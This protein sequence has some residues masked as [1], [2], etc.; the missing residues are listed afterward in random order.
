MMI[1]I[2]GF[3][4]RGDC[5]RC[6]ELFLGPLPFCT[7]VDLT[8]LSPRIA[9]VRTFVDSV[10][11]SDGIHGTLQCRA[12]SDVEYCFAAKYFVDFQPRFAAIATLAKTAER[13][14]KRERIFR[15]MGAH[16]E[17]AHPSLFKRR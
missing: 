9:T 8:Y 3:I 11:V 1:D 17:N 13:F 15:V 16:R 6:Q 12:E 10:A 2:S 5:K 4:E 7:K 14:G